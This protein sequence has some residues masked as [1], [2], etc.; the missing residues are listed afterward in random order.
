MKDESAF[1]LHMA[2]Y[3][4]VLDVPNLRN[5]SVFHNSFAVR[6]CLLSVS[7]GSDFLTLLAIVPHVFISNMINRTLRGEKNSVDVSKT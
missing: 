3:I 4:W 1:L 7:I 2:G 6:V 5:S